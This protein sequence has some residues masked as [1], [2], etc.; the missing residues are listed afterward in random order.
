MQSEPGVAGWA[1]SLLT[2]RAGM[3]TL[4]HA[5]SSLFGQRGVLTE[6]AVPGRCAWFWKVRRG[7]LGPDDVPGEWTL[8]AVIERLV[9]GTGEPPQEASESSCVI[10]AAGQGHSGGCDRRGPGGR[11][12]C[13]EGGTPVCRSAWPCRVECA[14]AST[15]SPPA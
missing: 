13:S 5:G 2:A 10:P 8:P 6:G 14:R 7:R 12:P 9:L 15:S 3:G 4:W 11:E 1:A